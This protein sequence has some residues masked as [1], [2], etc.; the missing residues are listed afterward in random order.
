MNDYN[1]NLEKNSANFIP[2]TPISF[3]ERTSDIYPNYEAV[4]YK[5]QIGRAHV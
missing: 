3:L 1:K 4:I 2:L 5:K